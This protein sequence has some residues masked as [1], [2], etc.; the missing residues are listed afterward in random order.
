[1]LYYANKKEIVHN[2]NE[3]KY[4]LIKLCFLLLYILAYT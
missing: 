4:I 2:N 1:M 3:E